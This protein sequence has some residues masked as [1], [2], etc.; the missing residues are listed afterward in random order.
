MSTYTDAMMTLGNKLSEEGWDARANIVYHAAQRM[1]AMEQLIADLMKD[2]E[3]DK[4]SKQQER[5]A[6]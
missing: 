6:S 3:D 2:S 5:Q 1:E 4:E